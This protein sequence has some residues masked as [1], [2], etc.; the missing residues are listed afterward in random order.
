MSLTPGEREAGR[1]FRTRCQELLLQVPATAVCSP[2]TVW[3]RHECRDIDQGAGTWAM[4][5]RQHY[6]LL[7]ATEG[8]EEGLFAFIFRWGLCSRCGLRVRSGTGRFVIARDNPPE[9]GAIVAYQNRAV[10]AGKASDTPAS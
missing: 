5:L 10:L 4:R 1:A 3:Y 2:F 9:K 8:A 7:P 6:W